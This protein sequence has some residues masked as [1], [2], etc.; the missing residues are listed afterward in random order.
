MVI[1]AASSNLILAK[2]LGKILSTEVLIAN[3][4][5]FSDNE[6]KVQIN[7]DLSNK[8][9]LIVLSYACARGLHVSIIPPPSVI[10][11]PIH[12]FTH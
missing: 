12:S 3:T 5:K 9:A 7:A 10:H 4:K 2:N 11:P 6:L 1:I 8:E